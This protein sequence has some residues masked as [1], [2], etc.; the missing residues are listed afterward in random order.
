VGVRLDPRVHVLPR[1]KVPASVAVNPVRPI[2]AAA[3]IRAKAIVSRPGTGLS[4]EV[5][6]QSV[7]AFTV[8]S[9]TNTF[10]P[11]TTL[12]RWL[13]S[14]ANCQSPDLQTIMPLIPLV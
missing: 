6:N 3:A 12:S 7:R 14:D 8:P 10:A 11:F 5:T 2:D 4:S 9:V 13:K 1:K